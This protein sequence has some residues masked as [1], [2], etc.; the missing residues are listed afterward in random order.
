MPNAIIKKIREK[1]IYPCGKKTG[2]VPLNQYFLCKANFTCIR[3][4][5]PIHNIHFQLNIIKK[6]NR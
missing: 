2:E 4:D 5:C 6:S 3:T 1:E